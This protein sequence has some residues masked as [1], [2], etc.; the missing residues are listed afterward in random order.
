[1]RISV[2]ALFTRTGLTDAEH[3]PLDRRLDSLRPEHPVADRADP[4]VAGDPTSGAA[5]AGGHDHLG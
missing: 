4:P 2:R 3:F 1:V 5:G